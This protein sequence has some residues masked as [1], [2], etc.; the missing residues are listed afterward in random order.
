MTSEQIRNLCLQVATMGTKL[1]DGC[2]GALSLMQT[3]ATWEV[4]YQLA[5]AN[6][7]ALAAAPRIV[8]VRCSMCQ[9][10]GRAAVGDP[11]GFCIG[12]MVAA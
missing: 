6:E 5:V 4:A 12:V 3:Q 11:C 8:D 9:R 2:D 1:D 7:R 10:A